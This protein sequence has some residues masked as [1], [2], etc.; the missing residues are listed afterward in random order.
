VW[1]AKDGECYDK[2]NMPTHTP[3]EA[4]CGT[5]GKKKGSGEK[6]F[7]SKTST[8]CDCEKFCEASKSK[9]VVVWEWKKSGER[10]TCYSKKANGR[11]A[12]SWRKKDTSKYGGTF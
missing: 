5:T 10:C 7:S 11:K 4:Y 8:S 2:N 3:T 1:K 12:L 6:A 9:G